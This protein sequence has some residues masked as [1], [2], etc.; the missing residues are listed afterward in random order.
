MPRLRHVDC[1]EPGFRRRRAGRGFVYLDER[2]APLRDPAVIER[3]RALA[4]PPAWTDVWICRHSNGHLQAVGT[5]AAGRRQYLY[6]PVWRERRDRKKFDD[7]LE[8][9]RALP[10]LRER[11]ERLLRKRG[12]PRERV[13]GF[14]VALLDR[15]LFRVGSEQYAD[16]NGTYGLTTL[17]RRHVTVQGS[18]GVVFDYPGKTGA[19][20]VHTVAGRRLRSV[21]AE[22]KERPGRHRA[23]LAYANGS[24]WSEVDAADVNAF[25]KEAAGGDF[26]AKDFRTWH[27]TVEA[28][29]SLVRSAEAPTVAGRKR[30]V[31]QAAADVA[32]LLGNTPAVS[33]A[34]YIDPRVFDLYHA[35]TTISPRAAASANGDPKGRAVRERAVLRLLGRG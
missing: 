20:R 22:L 34:S 11:S 6:H 4:I 9:A 35:G 29:A 3:I 30:A 1:A 7:M 12:L 33:K 10:G 31:N 15:G 27:G 23:F 32:E 5:D 8:F 19:R 2:G 18:D 13:L 16:D 14:A 17:E 21:A 28:A 25:I 24:G 26:T